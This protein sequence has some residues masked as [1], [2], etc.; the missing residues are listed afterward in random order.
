MGGSKPCQSPC[1][2]CGSPLQEEDDYCP[3]CGTPAA[4]DLVCQVHRG[5]PADGVCMVC[6]LPFCRACGAYVEGVFR[7][8]EHRALQEA[9]RR[10][11]HP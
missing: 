6:R 1:I 8:N 4:D 9:P 5:V 10:I 2:R 3:E 7:C 11:A